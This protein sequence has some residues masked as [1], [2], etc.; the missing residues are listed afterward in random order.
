MDCN[1][2]AVDVDNELAVVHAFVR[3]KYR[4]KFPELESLVSNTRVGHGTVS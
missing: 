2:L 4:F 1:R 3:D